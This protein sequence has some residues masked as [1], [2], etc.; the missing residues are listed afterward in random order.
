MRALRGVFFAICACGLMSACASAPM[1]LAASGFS[2]NDAVYS[3]EQAS[4]RT[5]ADALELAYEGHGWSERSDMMV[6]AR[7]WMDRLAGQSGSPEA[8]A[9]PVMSAYLS[10]SGL[11]ELDGETAAAR[12]AA[13]LTSAGNLARDIDHAATALVR[14]DGTYSRLA[15]TRDLDHVERSIAHTRHALDNFQDAM[16]RVDDRLRVQDRQRLDRLYGRLSDHADRLSDRA[17]EI[18]GM[19]RNT[20]TDAVS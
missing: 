8:V 6:A 4:L 15:L 12:L 17:D 3:P 19:R 2:V 11:L 13:D 20:L 1:S 9:P 14:S 18:A 7:G 16:N 10:E 5:S